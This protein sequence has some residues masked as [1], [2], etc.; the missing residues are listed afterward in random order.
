MSKNTSALLRGVID[1]AREQITVDSFMWSGTYQF[2]LSRR[3]GGDRVS[4]R[5]DEDLHAFLVE[6][7]KTADT[8]K[9]SVLCNE[10][11]VANGVKIE[12]FRILITSATQSGNDITVYFSGAKGNV[13]SLVSADNEHF[14]TSLCA[15]RE[16]HRVDSSVKI[17]LK[18]MATMQDA[19]STAARPAN[20]NTLHQI[21]LLS[22]RLLASNDEQWDFDRRQG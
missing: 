8:S 18:T 20:E 16:K 11:Y 21:A 10:S 9:T 14:Q 5:L 12:K 7:I 19:G 13:P 4:L 2:S 15:P 3:I 17:L 22:E 1:H 6:R